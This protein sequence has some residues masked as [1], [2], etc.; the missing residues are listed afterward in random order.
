[1]RRHLLGTALAA[2]ICYAPSALAC[3]G[4]FGHGIE[5]APS[6]K[7]VIHQDNGIESYT[8]S[9]HFCGTATDFGLILPIPTQLAQAP[10]L[11]SA[12]LV[13]Q[14][15]A[16]SAPIVKK[17]T[18]CL[19]DFGAG[20]GTSGGSQD[21]GSNGVNVV[22]KGQVGIFDYAVLKAD[23]PAAFTDWLDANG[24]PYDPNETSAFDYYV[25]K[26]WYF[27]AFRVTASDTAPPAGSKLCGDLGP[28]T[29]SFAA[30]P[31]VI[32]ARIAA[33][34]TQ[35]QWQFGWQVFTIG[36]SF[37]TSQS[38]ESST[39]VSYADE[40]T[41]SDLTQYPEIAGIAAAGDR[42]TKLDI[43]FWGSDLTQDITLSPNP[44]QTPFRDTVY[45]I[46]YVECDAG[47]A[48]SAGSAGSG[49]ASGSG[50]LAGGSNQGSPGDAVEAGGGGC[51]LSPAGTA[52]G[53]GLAGFLAALG[54]ALGHRRR[55][56]R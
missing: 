14:L 56:R 27:V 10:E 20:G 46:T 41:E 4:G 49:G 11:A 47:T 30:D 26:G 22:D 21:A 34:D 5:V 32:P 50:G 7:I 52:S 54:L 55:R 3:G 13:P 19:G 39:N 35:H 53:I 8:F 25:A 17:E 51:S 38:S 31:L 45:D 23:T 18:A 43:S 33:V 12:K 16:L 42:V 15:D 37:M 36:P 6:Q 1:M 9:P 24:F 2:S 29:V 40:L 48:G 28:I 44:S